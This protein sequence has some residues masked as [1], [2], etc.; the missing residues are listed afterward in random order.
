MED[1]EKRANSSY[2]FPPKF[3]KRYVDD[4]CMALKKDQIQLFIHHLKSLE[5]SINF[6]VE[7]ESNNKTCI[8]GHKNR[9]LMKNKGSQ[10]VNSYEKFLSFDSHHL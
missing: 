10:K 3:W 4:V 5:E 7:L 8:F 6:T 2:N 9:T 1:V